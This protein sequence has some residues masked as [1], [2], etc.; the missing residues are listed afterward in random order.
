MKENIVVRVYW[1]KGAVLDYHFTSEYWFNEF[2]LIQK[3]LIVKYE[4]I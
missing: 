2:I 4:L 3:K 1:R